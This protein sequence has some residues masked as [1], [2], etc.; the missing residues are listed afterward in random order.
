[1]FACLISV[2]NKDQKSR[3]SVGCRNEEITGMCRGTAQLAFERR[4]QCD[5]IEQESKNQLIRSNIIFVN[6]QHWD[7]FGQGIPGKTGKQIMR[8]STS[9]CPRI[10]HFSNLRSRNQEERLKSVVILD[11]L[12]RETE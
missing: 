8:H 6:L 7:W 3:K 9:I 10:L 2:Q 5:G 12:A 1:L 4:H 11:G